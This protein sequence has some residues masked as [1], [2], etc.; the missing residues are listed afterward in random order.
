MR[1]YEPIPVSSLKSTTVKAIHKFWDK[2]Y[3]LHG[4]APA[5]NPDG[6]YANPLP[7]T[8]A[9]SQVL[10]N[11]DSVAQ[12]SLGT[13][14]AS[15]ENEVFEQLPINSTKVESLIASF[16]KEGKI[17][18]PIV[19]GVIKTVEGG[20]GIVIAGRHR[21]TALLTMA[22]LIPG[23]SELTVGC[24]IDSRY[25]S[26]RELITAVEQYN[27]SRSVTATEKAQYRLTSKG[28]TAD[29]SF[30]DL[31]SMLGDGL[32]PS[33]MGSIA[34]VAGRN[35][36]ESRGLTLPV[37]SVGTPAS[38]AALGNFAN[39]A[40]SVFS[41]KSG[42][43]E[44]PL[45]TSGKVTAE[46]LK[47]IKAAWAVNV[48]T[49]NGKRPFVQVYLES[50]L[51]TLHSNWSSIFVQL[52]NGADSV[53]FA[54]SSSA[55]GRTVGAAVL[56]GLLEAGLQAASLAENQAAEKKAASKRKSAASSLKS[57][58]QAY[59]HLVAVSGTLPAEAL[60]SALANMAATAE[61]DL[62]ITAQD[63]FAAMQNGGSLPELESSLPVAAPQVT[64]TPAGGHAISL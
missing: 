31:F 10:T 27:V 51:A 54:R 8:G 3:K 21:L 40:L 12:V 2:V 50:V 9:L 6:T 1:T 35:W 24:Y 4:V 29:A 39:A 28:V 62:G 20:S 5:L 38:G 17:I 32:K 47:S 36:F 26:Q 55:V 16:I 15:K 53:N 58:Y 13:L 48:D 18:A 46:Q 56:E 49:P 22:Q 42:S 45:V 57:F 52:G 43:W 14:A 11:M 63:F 61:A 25:T 64:A 23:A 34:R 30:E 41:T 59:S 37:D 19:L 33:D 44:N 7:S 60:Q